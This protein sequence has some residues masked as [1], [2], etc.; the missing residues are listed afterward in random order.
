MPKDNKST[1]EWQGI[2]IRTMQKDIAWVQSGGHDIEKEKMER[3]KK[4][5]ERKED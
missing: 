1:A 5:G 3:Q 4:E 2:E